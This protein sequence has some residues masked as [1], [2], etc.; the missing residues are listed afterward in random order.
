MT[1]SVQISVR[2]YELDSLGHLN[3]AVYHSYAEH[4][5]VQ[6]MRALGAGG[7]G[8]ATQGVAPVLV[9]SRARY[10]KELRVG[11]EVDVSCDLNLGDGKVFTMNSVVSFPDGRVSAEI[12]ATI[13]LI[14]TT[15][16]RLVP[17]P[18]ERM[19]K[20]IQHPEILDGP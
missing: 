6:L 11:Q 3:Q 20:L 16:R 2:S 9:E 18:R 7:D 5:R 15:T 13:G 19:T 10:R 1:F 4:A 17:D 14:D 12:D 8:F